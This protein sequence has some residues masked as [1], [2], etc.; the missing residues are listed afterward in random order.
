MR[1]LRRFVPVVLSQP[2]GTGSGAD[3]DTQT[4]VRILG[5][6]SNTQ[7]DAARRVFRVPKYVHRI[8]LVTICERSTSSELAKLRLKQTT[9][10][11]SSWIALLRAEFDFSELAISFGVF[12]RK[13]SSNS[14]ASMEIR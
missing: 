7:P 1:E 8:F 4:Q 11:S 6:T 13:S 3:D 12:H 9:S 14:A 5:S 2:N 10:A